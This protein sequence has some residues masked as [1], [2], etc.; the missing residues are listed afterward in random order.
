MKV[1]VVDDDPLTL[2]AISECIKADGF[3]VICGENG[4]E[5]MGLWEREC[6]DLICLDIMMPELNG[7]EL[8][9][10]IR[11]RDGK[12]PI[13]F[14]S[15]KN[16]ER[17]LVLGLKLGADDFIRKPFNRAELMARIHAL[18]RRVEPRS[19]DESFQLQDLVVEPSK[20]RGE[21][22]GE[23]IELTPREISILRLLFK[24][25][26]EA[27]HRDRLLDECWGIDYFP[28]SRTLDQHIFVLR[29]K[30]ACG[31]A[32]IIETVRGVGYRVS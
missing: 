11:E 13:L 14:L 28:D 7:Y 26:G 9:Q 27:V 21:R 8:C 24:C 1:L 18:M 2:E 31:G 29:K 22:N 23:Q 16:E 12:V 25:Q 32:P 15:A 20:L 17:D 30:I 4:V 5:G 3:E 10:K 19:K 6:P